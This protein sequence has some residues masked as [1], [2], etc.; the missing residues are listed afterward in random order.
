[1]QVL[2]YN[3]QVPVYSLE[4][5]EI[6]GNPNF[7]VYQFAGNLPGQSDLLIPHRKDYYL[8]VFMR[9]GGRLSMTQRW[10]TGRVLTG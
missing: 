2:S 9:R 5:D 4:P 10:W 6:N 8:L 1:M 3:Q 7:R